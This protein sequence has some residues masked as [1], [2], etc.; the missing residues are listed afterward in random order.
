MNGVISRREHAVQT[1]WDIFHVALELFRTVG[2]ECTTIQDICERANVSVG[3]FYYYYRSKQDIVIDLCR[4]L[5]NLLEKN[6]MRRQFDDPFAGLLEV[7]RSQMGYWQEQGFRIPTQ[8][9]K[10]QL[11]ASEQFFLDGDRSF[12]RI[13]RKLIMQAFAEKRIQPD[14]TQETVLNTLLRMIR[15]EMYDWCLHDGNYDLTGQAC[16]DIQMVFAYFRR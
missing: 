7:V 1:K 3:A 8:I 9:F 11:T 10:N 13:L 6:F 2:Y 12:Y 14:F 5:D 16:T 15:G 4:K